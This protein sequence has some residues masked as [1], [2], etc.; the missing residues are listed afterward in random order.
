MKSGMRMTPYGRLS[1]DSGVTAF[2]SEAK[3][4]TVKFVDG[5]KYTYTYASAGEQHIEQ[6]KLLAQAGRGLCG[7]ISK[8]VRDNYASSN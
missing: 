8:H 4:I 6:M 7:Y 3:A 5:R 1:G 2:C